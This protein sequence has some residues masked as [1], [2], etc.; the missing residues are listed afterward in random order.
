MQRPPSGR[1]GLLAL[2]FFLLFVGVPAAASLYIDARWYASLGH[3]Q[4]FSTLLWTRVL[5]GVV[6]GLLVGAC[7]YGN[8]R[9][10]FGLSSG[11]QPLFLHDP[12]G[13][14]RINLADIARRVVLPACVVIGVLSGLLNHRHWDTWLLFQ[15]ATDF[16]AQDPIFGR[17]VSFYVFKLPLLEAVSSIVLWTLGL[18]AA[19][20]AAAYSV[21]GALSFGEV[22]TLR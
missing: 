10:A 11:A 20:S 17:D 16:G 13:V 8:V 3:G 5:L 2:V 9:L 7:I 14:P 12:D 1:L 4:V 15:N 19:L 22:S 21:S 6:V 18:S